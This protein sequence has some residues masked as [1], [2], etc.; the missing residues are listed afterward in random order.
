MSYEIV[1]FSSYFITRHLLSF[2]LIA[3]CLQAQIKIKSVMIVF[4][5]DII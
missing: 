2:Y 1:I 3:V 5:E 4:H